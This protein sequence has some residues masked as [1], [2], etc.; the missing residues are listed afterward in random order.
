MYF[1]LQK[2]QYLLAYTSS[3]FPCSSDNNT[4]EIPYKYY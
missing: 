1:E 3:F 2:R 4:I